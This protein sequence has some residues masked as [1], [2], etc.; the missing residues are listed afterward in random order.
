MELTVIPTFKSDFL[1][2][3]E[4]TNI[5]NLLVICDFAKSKKLAVLVDYLVTVE[6][7]NQKVELFYKSC[8]MF[9]QMNKE[10]WDNIKD[11]DNDS[12]SQAVLNNYKEDLYNEFNCDTA[13]L[14]KL[15]VTQLV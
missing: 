9:L 7:E 11:L 10:F 13:K 1:I 2:K 6:S 14:D 12:Q 5:E 4:T 3:N 8:K 15:K